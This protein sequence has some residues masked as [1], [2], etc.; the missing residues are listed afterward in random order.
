MKVEIDLLIKGV[1]LAARAANR[2]GHNS[3][4]NSTRTPAAGADVRRYGAERTA[5]AYGTRQGMDK[6]L[7]IE[8][9]TSVVNP[10]EADIAT[11]I[12]SHRRRWRRR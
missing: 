1:E 9:L 5:M 7:F 6:F 3:F 8:G 4:M 10:S 12:G 2:K 11:I